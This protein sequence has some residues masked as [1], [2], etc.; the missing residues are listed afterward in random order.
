MSAQHPTHGATTPGRPPVVGLV[1]QDPLMPS[2]RL[3][4]AALRPYIAAA[5]LE[6]RV[7]ALGRGREWLRVLRLAAAWRASDAL[8]FQQVKLLAGERAFVARRCDR[9]VLD[10]DDAIMFRRP[11]REDD[12]GSTARWRQRRF[13][14]MARRCRFVVAG[15]RSLAEMIGD[16]GGPVA[17]LPTPVDLAAYPPA[18]LPD[19]ATVRLGWIGLGSN[20]RYLERLA[21]VFARLRAGDVRFEVRVISDRLPELTDVPC[22]LVPWSEATE[23]RDLA[24][25]D[26][27]LAPLADDHWTRGKAGYRCIQY[28]AAG[29]PAVATPVGGQREIV[30]DGETGLWAGDPEAWATAL[31]RLC[32]DA[33]LRRRLGTAAR[34]AAARYDLRPFAER[35]LDLLRRLV[36]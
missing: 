30:G 34:A 14:A 13:H 10:V 24:E 16:T 19:R 1:T 26:V 9:W 29:L 4:L 5:G 23:G 12:P 27:G 18:S 2:F 36:V 17:V 22:T 21:P 28:A 8:V 11:R 31:R 32:G 20:L 35:Y 15:S 25:C 33:A 7:V 6:P 3:R